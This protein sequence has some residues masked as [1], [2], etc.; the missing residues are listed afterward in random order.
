MVIFFGI[1]IYY[2]KE[3]NEEVVHNNRVLE[4]RNV[5]VERKESHR[6]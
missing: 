5:G 6:V 4:H 1:G 2:P 3:R